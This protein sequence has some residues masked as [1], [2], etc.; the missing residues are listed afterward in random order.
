MDKSMLFYCLAAV[1]ISLVGSY[2]LNRYIVKGLGRHAI[3]T[4]VPVSE[5]ALKTL[6]AFYFGVPFLP[7]HFL[8]G[9]GEAIYDLTHSSSRYAKWAAFFSIVS[10][11]FFGSVTYAGLLLMGKP[12]A[13][14]M[15]AILFHGLWNYF[16]VALPGE[17][18]A[19]GVRKKK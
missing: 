14:V 16:M 19:S 12:V 15:A 2:I 3:Y 8:F 4:L 13:A 17:K 9:L 11:A 10:H 7:V 1:V 18:T 5:E 6:P